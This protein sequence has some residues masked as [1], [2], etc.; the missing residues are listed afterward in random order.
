MNRKTPEERRFSSNEKIKSMGIACYEQLPMTESAEEVSLKT[1]EEICRR[2]AASMISIQLA[3]DISAGESYEES[4]DF[5]EP[6]LARFDVG[7]DLNETEKSLFDKTYTMEDAML[8]TWTYECC[9]VLLWA[10]GLIDDMG[11]PS[12][13]CDCMKAVNI[14]SQCNDL[15]ELMEKCSPRDIEEILDE[16]DL[17][18]RY[19]WACVHKQIK[20]ETEIGELYHDVVT[21]RRRGLE[22]LISDEDDWFEISLDT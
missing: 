2:A 19:H 15:N 6:L 10:L 5:F 14:I 20:P 17:H 4:L 16:L 9:W 21:E 18:Y 11:F 12:D 22:W 13:T 1:T 3:C 7:N 8:I